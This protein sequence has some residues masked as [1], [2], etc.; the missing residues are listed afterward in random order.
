MP[1]PQLSGHTD[2]GFL[3]NLGGALVDS[4]ANST[5]IGNNAK[6]IR[7]IE[8]EVDATGIDNHELNALKM[9]DTAAKA[10]SQRGELT[11]ILHQ[12]AYHG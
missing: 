11:I 6:V 9:V 2:M 4:G 8:R 1:I 7:K 10:Y 12:F 3:G 5:I